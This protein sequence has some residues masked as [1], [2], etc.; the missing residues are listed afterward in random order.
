MKKH[1]C[2]VDLREMFDLAHKSLCDIRD[3][4][5]SGSGCRNWKLLA[6]R[7]PQSE[8]NKVPMPGLNLLPPL[9]TEQDPCLGNG[10]T[11]K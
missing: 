3:N 9:D 10:P 1:P 2:N 4:R 7:C 5:K 11:H 6:T 8:E